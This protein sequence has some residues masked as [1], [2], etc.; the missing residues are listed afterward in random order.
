MATR[1]LK[2]PQTRYYLRAARFGIEAL[3]DRKPLGAEFLFM[4]VGILASLRTVQFA[5]LN[6]DSTLSPTHKAVI[7]KWKATTPLD[8]PEMGFIK[9]SRDLILKRGAFQAFA[10]L[11][12]SSTGEG[13]N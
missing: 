9:T 6:H 3:A 7:E 2:L 13:S 11:S 4:C 5:L 8:G 10:T 12:E 1:I